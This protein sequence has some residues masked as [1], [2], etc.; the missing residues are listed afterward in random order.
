MVSG[1][2]HAGSGVLLIKAIVKKITARMEHIA[3]MIRLVRKPA[4]ETGT[5]RIPEKSTTIEARIPAAISVID[6][7]RRMKNWVNRKRPGRANRKI[8]NES[9]R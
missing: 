8:E 4:P 6:W 2:G 3:G 9:T 5:I 7:Y 1:W